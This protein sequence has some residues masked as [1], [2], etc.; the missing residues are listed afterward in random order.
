MKTMKKALFMLFMLL[1]ICLPSGAQITTSRLSFKDILEGKVIPQAQMHETFVRGD[2][3][4]RLRLDSFHCV[5]FNTDTS[6]LEAVEKIIRQDIASSSS[7][8]TEVDG[9]VL[10]YAFVDLPESLFGKKRYLG[11]Q[12]KPIGSDFSVTIL[13][14]TGDTTAWELKKIIDKRN[15]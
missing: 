13:Y 5:R 2:K 15:N 1:A 12:V 8:E 3:L 6:T 9:G 7:A 11:Y 10:V 14:L 4:K